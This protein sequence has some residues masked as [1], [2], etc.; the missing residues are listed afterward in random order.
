[1]SYDEKNYSNGIS[2]VLIDPN[3]PN[4]FRYYY[5]DN[6]TQP[7]S[8]ADLM[9]IKRLALPPAWTNVWISQDPN[10]HIQAM[11]KDTKGRKQYKYHQSHI[12]TAIKLKFTRLQRFISS[13]KQ[14]VRVLNRDKKL[15]YYSK[16]KIAGSMVM[17]IQRYHFRIGKEVYARTNKSYGISSLRKKHVHIKNGDIYLRFKGKSNQ[18]LTYKITDAYFVGVI[19]KLLDLPGDKLF[20]YVDD[21]EAKIK[22]I[23]EVDLNHYIQSAI[24]NQFTIKDFRTLG[25]NLYYIQALLDITKK[26]TKTRKQPSSDVPILSQKQIKDNLKQ[27]L[28]KTSNHL[29]HTANVAKKSYVMAMIVELYQT[30]PAYFIINQDKTADELLSELLELYTASLD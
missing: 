9:R 30:N 1:M 27:A 15:P 26:T 19:M 3:I 5:N 6:P 28:L 17:M 8:E 20:Q 14:L 2:R 24:G 7:V 25:S 11:G 16:N 12:D 23:T 22:G 29:K 4:V 13:L 10:D 18:N 21:D